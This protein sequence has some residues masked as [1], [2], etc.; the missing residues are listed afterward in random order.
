MVY[1]LQLSRR[2]GIEGI[3]AQT[4]CC[5]LR[6]LSEGVFSDEDLEEGNIRSLTGRWRKIR[7]LLALFLHLLIHYEIENFWN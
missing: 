3:L 6:I 4:R 5:R 2:K 7:T 1:P